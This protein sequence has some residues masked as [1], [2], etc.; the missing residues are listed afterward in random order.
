MPPGAPSQLRP[1]EGVRTWTSDQL[2]GD[3]RELR[4]IHR[5]EEYR[6]RLTHLDKLILTK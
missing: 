5:G 1:L 6:L 2:F 4:I 3:E